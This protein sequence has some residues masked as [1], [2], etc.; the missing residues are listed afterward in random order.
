MSTATTLAPLPH[1]NARVWFERHLPELYS[2]C[3]TFFRELSPEER[4][5]ATAETV[6]SAF[7][8]ALSA[9]GRGK[10]QLLTPYTLVSFFGRS[11]HDGRRIGGASSTDALS[12]AGRRRHKLRVVSFDEDQESAAPLRAVVMRISDTLVDPKR[13]RPLE[14]TRRNIDYLE[15]LDH[16]QASP[17]VRRVFEFFCATNGEGRQSDLARE[18][19]VSPSRITLLKAL[20]TVSASVAARLRGGTTRDRVKIGHLRACPGVRCRVAR[21]WP[22]ART[23]RRALAPATGR[24]VASCRFQRL[25]AA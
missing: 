6:A 8:Y 19:G 24:R 23:A 7:K 16:E 17:Q 14:N 21:G 15:I 9:A 20:A 1:S 5:E 12:E 18:M 10:L 22:A 11:Y 4:E 25:A 13:D 2:R 3:R